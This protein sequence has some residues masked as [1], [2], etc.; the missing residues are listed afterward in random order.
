MLLATVI[1]EITSTPALLYDN[2]EDYYDPNFVLNFLYQGEIVVV[3]NT[4]FFKE[5]ELDFGF[6]AITLSRIMTKF[7]VKLINRSNLKLV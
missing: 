3:L 5:R 1:C 4:C 2:V 6:F 7:G